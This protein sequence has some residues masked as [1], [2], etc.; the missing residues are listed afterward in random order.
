MHQTG[1]VQVTINGG[2]GNLEVTIYANVQ[3]T[4]SL[5]IGWGGHSCASM[6]KAGDPFSPFECRTYVAPRA[7]QI[8]PELFGHAL[9]ALGFVYELF[10]G[11]VSCSAHLDL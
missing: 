5:S 10:G 2:R 6:R 9:F 7:L 8:N 4:S 11:A 3:L 1:L